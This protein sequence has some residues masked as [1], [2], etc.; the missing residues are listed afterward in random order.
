MLPI[1]EKSSLECEYEQN[2]LETT[3]SMYL[4]DRGRT[5]IK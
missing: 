5:R 2:L 4:A 1:S 3:E